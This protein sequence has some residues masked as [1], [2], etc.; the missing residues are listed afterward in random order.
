MTASAQGC[1]WL[2]RLKVVIHIFFSM[3]KHSLEHSNEQN[4]LTIFSSKVTPPPMKHWIV[5][6]HPLKYKIQGAN[7]LLNNAPMNYVI[8]IMTMKAHLAIKINELILCTW[9]RIH[10]ENTMVCEN[11]IQHSHEFKIWK[12]CNTSYDYIHM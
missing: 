6:F 10:V 11:S 4:I 9:T 12:Q 8:I 7:S 5:C 1:E 3:V 2:E